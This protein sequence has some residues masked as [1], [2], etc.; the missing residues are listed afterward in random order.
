MSVLRFA[1]NAKFAL[2][3][4]YFGYSQVSR[5]YQSRRSLCFQVLLVKLKTQ[6]F[7]CFPI[8]VSARIITLQFILD[9]P[10]K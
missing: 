2:V 5:T 10:H 3:V 7:E 1:V 4:V 6:C 9:I 8:G